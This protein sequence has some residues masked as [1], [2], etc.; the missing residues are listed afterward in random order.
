MR[1]GGDTLPH[2]NMKKFLLYPFMALSVVGLFLST[3]IHFSALVGK[4]IPFGESVWIL[5]VGIFVVWIPAVMVGIPLTKD[6]KQKD[7]RKALLRGCP[8]WMKAL[9][10]AFFVYAFINFAIFFATTAKESPKSSSGETPTAVFRGFSGHWMLFYSASFAIMYSAIHAEQV[11]K[12]R[13]CVAGHIVSP[14]ANY[15]DEC[16]QP[17]VSEHVS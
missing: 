4:Q 14:T 12:N 15:C 16:G 7:L 3:L 1:K 9:M 10:L 5:H 13:R 2:I 6:F 11:D 17:V 8:N